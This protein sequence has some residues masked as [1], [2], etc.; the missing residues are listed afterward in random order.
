MMDLKTLPNKQ[1]DEKVV[2]FLRR[3]W[4]APLTIVLT[5]ILLIIV[6]TVLVGY[7]AD[8]QDWLTHSTLEPLLVLG[9]SM[10]VM[11]VW[12]IASI[13]FTDFYLDTWIVTNKRIIN[14]E[15]MGLFHRHASELHLSNIQ[16]ITSDTEG[17][18]H[19]MFNYGHV[20]IQTAAEEE[21]FTFKDVPE[22][23]QVKDAIL[24][25]VETNKKRRH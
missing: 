20:Y 23:D 2:L 1:K 19:T 10:Y 11:A 7:F 6:P 16:D 25:L 13:E 12:L 5:F 17:F 14:I 4:F 9:S 18:L 24:K 22:P 15:Q 8:Q 21:R 3:H